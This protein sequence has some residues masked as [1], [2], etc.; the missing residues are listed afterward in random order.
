MKWVTATL[1]INNCLNASLARFTQLET[2]KLETLGTP[3][4]TCY[5]RH[6]AN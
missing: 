5:E 1:S 2:I 4:H 6:A 3:R